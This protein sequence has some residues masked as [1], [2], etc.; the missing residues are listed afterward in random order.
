MTDLPLDISIT[1]T[2]QLIESESD[3]LLLDCRNQ[4]EYDF[5]HLNDA[6]LIPMDEIT[7]RCDELSKEGTKQIVVYCHMGVRSQMVAR[8]LRENGFPTAQSMA[9]G[10][11]AWSVAIDPSLRRY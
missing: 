10:I 9:G 8:W 1:D 7:T 5:V 6:K 2:Q 4:D 11:D 3:V